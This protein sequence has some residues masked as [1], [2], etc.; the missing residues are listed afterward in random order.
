M[1][2]PRLARRRLVPWSFAVAAVI[3]SCNLHNS[4]GLGALSYPQAQ[5]LAYPNALALSLGRCARTSCTSPTRTSTCGTTAASVQSYNLRVHRTESCGA[6]RLPNARAARNDD[7]AA[8]A[9]DETDYATVADAGVARRRALNAGASTPAC[10]GRSRCPRLR[11][12]STPS[13]RGVLAWPRSARATSPG[14]R[15]SSRRRSATRRRRTAAGDTV[16]D[17]CTGDCCFDGAEEPQP[18][19]ARARAP[20][21]ATRAG[22]GRLARRQASVRAGGEPQPARLPRLSNRASSSCGGAHGLCRRGPRIDGPTRS[23]TRTSR[24]RSPAMVGRQ[25]VRLGVEQGATARRAAPTV[26]RHHARA[27]RLSACSSIATAASIP[28][29]RA[30]AAT[31]CPSA[32]ARSSPIPTQ[33]LLYVASASN[34]RVLPRGSACASTRRRPRRQGAQ[35]RAARAALPDHAAGRPGVSQPHDLRDLALDPRDPDRLYALVRGSQESIAFLQL[36]PNSLERD[37]RL[38]DAVRVG[39]G[40]SKIKYIEHRQAA[41]SC[42]SAATTPRRST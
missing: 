39:A 9:V 1:M 42:S 4:Q 6:Q 2:T 17:R 30:S 12:R 34:S 24:A 32:H 27:R 28:C 38:V 11:R 3:G 40:P 21:T 41:R 13:P 14:R 19:S 31:T 8:T 25:A 36:D 22:I 5:R 16:G 18:R 10:D 26:H 23:R 33:Q 7:G 15:T 29:S 20:S 35:D 37:V